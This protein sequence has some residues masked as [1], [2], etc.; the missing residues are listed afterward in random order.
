M[1]SDVLASALESLIRGVTVYQEGR[2]PADPDFP[3]VLV[4][5]SFPSVVERSAVRSVVA[6]EVRVRTTL[7]G[8]LPESV[9]WLGDR[10]CP[11]LE[12]ARPVVPGW[13]LGRV[14]E[15]PSGQGV[16]TDFDV[17]L[18]GGLHPVYTVVD[19]VLTAS[20]SPA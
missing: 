6:S 4:S 20:R 10:V 19:W 15:R 2:V 7:V 9:R 8:E 5:T 12:G 13:R 14:E 16:V 1:S 17:S 3:Y 11:V 18:P